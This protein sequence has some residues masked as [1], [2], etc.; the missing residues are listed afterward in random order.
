M[1][2]TPRSGRGSGSPPPRR[3]LTLRVLAQSCERLLDALDEGARR[4]DVVA[5]LEGDPALL[6]EALRRANAGEA[7]AGAVASAARAVDVLGVDGLARMARGVAT[8]DPLRFVSEDARWIVGF[9]AH[10]LSVHALARRIA[11]EVGAEHDAD[12]AA[13]A[14]L[15]DVGKLALPER[16]DASAGTPE[17]R[18][19]AERRRCG[20]D[21]AELGA[22]LARSWRLPERV[23]LAIEHHHGE[24]LGLGAIVR[25]ADL[26]AH[27]RE[28]RP[29]EPEQLMTV[30][31][32]AGLPPST[33]GLLL[34]EPASSLAT[35]QRRPQPID[36]SP[37]ELEV[38]R[39]L[40]AGRVPKQI[41]ADLGLAEATVRSHLRRIY[42]RLGVADRTQAVLVARDRGWFE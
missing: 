37:R 30:A 13:A 22:W 16:L 23:A 11:A 12:L 20:T 18:R 32:V 26:L 19:A 2:T 24:R 36:V 4:R 29:I 33:L 31:L 34:H 14:L 27:A 28:G 1:L 10:A 6:L 40:S 3:A 35:I 7:T 38:L 5:A 39:G 17:D 21:H 15:H 41:A 42:R 8:V 25:L 9:R